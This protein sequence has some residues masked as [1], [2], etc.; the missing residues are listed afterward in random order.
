MERSRKCEQA[1]RPILTERIPSYLTPH[2]PPGD[3]SNCSQVLSGLWARLCSLSF[4]SKVGMSKCFVNCLLQ[5]REALFLLQ[6][7]FANRWAP[8]PNGGVTVWRT[9][10]WGLG[11]ENWAAPR[12]LLFPEL[13]GGSHKFYQCPLNGIERLWVML[14]ILSYVKVKM[15]QY[16]E[17]NPL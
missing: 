1:N 2:G 3:S 12:W 9:G 15:T 14:S 11:T 6:Y 5:K 10:E 13:L 7:V 4:L 16:L 8:V 17:L